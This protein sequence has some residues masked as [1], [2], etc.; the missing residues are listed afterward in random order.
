MA[1]KTERRKHPRLEVRWPVK[2]LTGHSTIECES[3]NISA[4]GLFIYCKEP[5]PLYNIFRL[6]IMPPNR[7]AI[8]VKG[9]V[10]WSKR[11]SS[12]E[13]KTIYGTGVCFVEISDEDWH[14]FNDA[15]SLYL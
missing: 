7:Q 8:W 3:R 2:V 1:N 13:E 12:D 14:F 5:L 10:L 15:L 9:R 11:Y 4:N 6:S